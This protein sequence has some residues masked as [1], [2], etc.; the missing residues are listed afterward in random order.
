MS[1]FYES[2]GRQ[3]GPVDDAALAGL[4]NTGTVAGPTLVWRPG[5]A[6]WQP[7]QEIWA[8]SA[9]AANGQP[10]ALSSG[11]NGNVATAVVARAITPAEM[12]AGF[13]YCTECGR[14]H[15]ADDLAPVLDRRICGACKPALLQ[16]LREGALQPL[17]A[18]RYAGFSIRV[19][20]AVLDG[21]IQTPVNLV[22]S[23]LA[24]WLLGAPGFF[25]PAS[26]GSMAGLRG[27][28]AV[29][30]I[31]QLASLGFQ[32]AYGTFFVGRFGATPG[33]LVC[34]LRVR[35]SDGTALTYRRALWRALV[36]LLNHFTLGLSYILVAIDSEKR[37]VHDYLCDT[38]VVFK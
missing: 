14:G 2:A 37:G 15:A 34:G 4:V 32:M 11:N 1:W 8:A 19:G 36:N 12:L 29:N 28:L 26:S 7:Y 24:V 9:A 27:Q 33:M 18:Q 25:D 6:A 5:M 13:G 21:V 16:R 17:A 23:F 22:V 10:S 3:A 38:R 30:A 20:A 31:T 35:R